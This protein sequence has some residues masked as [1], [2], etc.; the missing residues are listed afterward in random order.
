M[1]QAQELCSFLPKLKDISSDILMYT[2]FTIEQLYEM[3]DVNVNAALKQISVLVDGEYIME[4]NNN[5]PMRGSDNQKMIFLDESLRVKYEQYMQK[6][7]EIQN[8]TIGNSVVSVGI[9][10]ADYQDKLKKKLVEKN[11]IVD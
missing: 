11:L 1:E 9:H 3:Q 8:F 2:G 4:R 7:N 6:G 10:S 5:C